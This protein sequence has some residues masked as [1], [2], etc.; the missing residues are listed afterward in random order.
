[1]IDRLPFNPAE[2][3][4]REIVNNDGFQE[5]NR[6]FENVS[7]C[8]LGFFLSEQGMTSICTPLNHFGV[9]DSISGSRGPDSSSR[10]SRITS[11]VLM[12]I[13]D[14]LKKPHSQDRPIGFLPR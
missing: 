8:R 12:E 10:Q 4:G 1:V 6:F 11:R 14:H 7:K 5:R 2:K 3:A 9:C 13:I